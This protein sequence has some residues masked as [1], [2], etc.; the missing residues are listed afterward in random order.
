MVPANSTGIPRAPAYSGADSLHYR[1]SGTGLS[2]PAARHSSRF[3]YSVASDL[4][5][6]YYPGTRVATPPVWALPRSI[7]STGGIVITFSSCGYLDVS[8][9]RVRFRP[10][11]MSGSL[12]TGC[13]IRISPDQ[14]VFAPP[15]SFSQLVTSFFASESQGIPH[16]P[17][18]FRYFFRSRNGL[19]SFRL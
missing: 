13:P 3:P 11:R 12:P 7:A 14:W 1:L 5:R 2:P 15:R 10:G 9:P 8:V 6:S 19:V 18:R 4:R 16:A 17:F